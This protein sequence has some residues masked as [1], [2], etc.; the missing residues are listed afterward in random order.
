MA[1]CVYVNNIRNRS[2]IYF[3]TIQKHYYIHYVQILANF[4]V[5][6]LTTL[7]FHLFLL[8][9]SFSHLHKKCYLLF[10]LM[11]IKTRHYS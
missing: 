4:K 3:T 7:N 9:V 10:S 6:K 1:S 2:F 5:I 8:K 11:L